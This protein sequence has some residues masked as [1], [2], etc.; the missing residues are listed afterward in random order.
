MVHFGPKFLGLDFRFKFKGPIGTFLAKTNFRMVYFG[1]NFLGL[2]LRFKFKGPIGSFLAQTK[3][4]PW[5][6]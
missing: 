6:R 5:C 3:I 4:H 2:D 1:P